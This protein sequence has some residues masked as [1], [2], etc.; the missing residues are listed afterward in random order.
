[1]KKNIPFLYLAI[2]LSIAC[3]E[4]PTSNATPVPVQNP[5]IGSSYQNPVYVD[6]KDT[7]VTDKTKAD[8]IKRHN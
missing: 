7:G 4:K 8:S 2:L 5:D 6:P 1:M 3:Q